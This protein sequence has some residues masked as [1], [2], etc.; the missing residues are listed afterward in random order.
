MPRPKGSKNKPKKAVQAGD[1]VAEKIAAQKELK[2][3]LE[4]EQADILAAIEKQ[5]QLLKAKKKEI[6]A[7]EKAIVALEAKQAQAAAI[8]AAA[9]QK[10]EIAQVVTKLVTSGKSPEEILE[11]LKK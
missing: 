7:A 3:S 1:Q 6:R 11:L 8:E 2:Q 4:A 10:E 9:A 5:K